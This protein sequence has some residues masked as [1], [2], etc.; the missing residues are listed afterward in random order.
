M[1][2]LADFDVVVV[3]AATDRR[4]IERMQ[5]AGVNVHIARRP[6]AVR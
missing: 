1:L 6:S 3:D 5:D 2:P 4:H